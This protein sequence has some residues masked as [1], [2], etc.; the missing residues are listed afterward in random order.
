M[1]IYLAFTLFN[2]ENPDTPGYQN[3]SAT[4][5]FK[6]IGVNRQIK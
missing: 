1:D 3:D 6:A 4:Y 5:T 2:K